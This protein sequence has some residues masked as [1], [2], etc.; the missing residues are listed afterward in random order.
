MIARLRREAPLLTLLFGFGILA[1][2]SLFLWYR[3]LVGVC[4]WQVGWLTCQAPTTTLQAVGIGALLI[5]VGILFAGATTFLLKREELFSKATYR[6]LFPLVACLAFLIVPLGS[7]DMTY[8]RAAGQAILEGVNPF[9]ESWPRSY[10]FAGNTLPDST[11]HGFSYGPLAAD[12]FVLVEK[13]SQGNPFLFLFLWKMLMV[14]ALIFLVFLLSQLLEKEVP[15]SQ[16]KIWLLF[17][18]ILLFEW[19]TNG[20]FDAL[21]V[22]TVLLAIIFARSR[23]WV[24]V[25]GILMVGV[26]LKFLPLFTAPWFFLW[27]WQDTGKNWS[28]RLKD[29]LLGGGVVTVLTVAA[30][31]PYWNGPK[32]FTPILMQSKWAVMSL[33]STVYYGLK[34]LSQSLLGEGYHWYLTRGVQGTLFV[35]LVW[36]LWPLIKKA[37][38]ALFFRTVWGEEQTVGAITLSFLVFLMVWQKSFWPWYTAWLLP[39]AWYCIRRNLIRLPKRL[40]IWICSAPFFFYPLWFISN[41]S[42]HNDP[43]PF[44]WFGAIV[45]LGVWG[46]PLFLLIRARVKQTLYE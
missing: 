20:H 10:V 15:T 35:L 14:G 26:W 17:F 34:P 31:A 41:T 25:A 1:V 37:F 29:L 27:W 30:W 13:A 24:F 2:P 19:V 18:P 45:A 8:Y 46:Y 28:V 6:W 3:S 39:F 12:L 16:K 23:Q 43:T 44:F 5:F 11:V 38:Q 4:A 7:S 40:W 32:V 36:L 33:F 22:I 21:W 42:I 9:V